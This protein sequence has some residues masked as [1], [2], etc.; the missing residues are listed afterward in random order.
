MPF[1]YKSSI[2]KCKKNYFNLNEYLFSI[3]GYTDNLNELLQKSVVFNKQEQYPDKTT[4]SSSLYQNNYQQSPEHNIGHYNNSS[5][6][7]YDRNQANDFNKR[8][9]SS[10]P[11]V[12]YLG[13]GK[14][15]I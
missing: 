11:K 12:P 15:Y 4:N 7:S 9:A 6:N 13:E 3:L 14:L 8:S 1:N 5:N 10:K 2:L